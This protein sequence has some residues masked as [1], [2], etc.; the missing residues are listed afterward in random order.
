MTF[1]LSVV[2]LKAYYIFE[3][4]CTGLLILDSD[5]MGFLILPV[6][7]AICNDINGRKKE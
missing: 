5:K 1:L 2:Y 4:L 6:L 3:Y 7:L